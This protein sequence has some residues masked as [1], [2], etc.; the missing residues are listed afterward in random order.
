VFCA[1]VF[2]DPNAGPDSAGDNKLKMRK[3][4]DSIVYTNDI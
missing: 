1:Q 3:S 2:M 4:I